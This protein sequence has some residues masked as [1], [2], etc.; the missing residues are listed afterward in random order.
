[1]DS[2]LSDYMADQESKELPIVLD[3]VSSLFFLRVN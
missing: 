2:D 1:M 3:K